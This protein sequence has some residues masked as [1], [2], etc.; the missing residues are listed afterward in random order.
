MTGAAAETA[1]V[2]F[3][4]RIDLVEYVSVS[5]QRNGSVR[6]IKHL[7]R[8]YM[9]YVMD[10]IFCVESLS[11]IAENADTVT[12]ISGSLGYPRLYRLLFHCK[13]CQSVTTPFWSMIL[14]YS[15]FSL[16]AMI[17]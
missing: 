12:T 4:G 10:S 3:M 5:R 11:C 2:L 7:L 1:A 8:E 13:R 14:A 9:T 16:V 17:Q 15:A 6:N